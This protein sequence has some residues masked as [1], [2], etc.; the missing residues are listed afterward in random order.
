MGHPLEE[1]G[2]VMKIRTFIIL[3][4]LIPGQLK[5]R[6]IILTNKLI[7]LSKKGL[8]AKEN[9]WG[10]M[11]ET[12]Q[13]WGAIFYP[14]EF[15][16]AIYKFAKNNMLIAFDEMQSVSQNRKTFWIPTL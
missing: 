8:N 5:I 3:I 11:L 12:Y 6:K 15:I 2:L 4:F 7:N 9:L 1:I 16:S 13:G 10:F 14:K